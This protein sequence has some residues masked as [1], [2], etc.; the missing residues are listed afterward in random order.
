M[1]TDSPIQEAVRAQWDRDSAAEQASR[2]ARPAFLL[3]LAHALVATAALAVVIAAHLLAQYTLEFLTA[4]SAFAVLAA[5]GF[6]S[7]YVSR[8]RV[9]E[10]QRRYQAR[11]FIRNI[12][13]QDMAM[14][15]D[16]TQLFNR[17]YF[18]DRLQR[19]L[20]QAR[21]FQ[22][23]LAVVVLDVDGLKS[24]NDVHGHRAGDLLLAA[25]GRL[26]VEYTRTCDVPAR[27][28]GD[29]FAVIMPETDKAGAFA[30]AGRLQRSLE[31]SSVVEDNGHRL[32][33]NVSLGVSGY[34]WGG[35]DVDQLV[36]WADTYMYAAKAARRGKPDAS[37]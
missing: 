11:L 25:M 18:Y 32:K 2:P 16:L 33:L 15:D 35:D 28:G 13:L 8:R 17:R 6:L 27:I 9:E 19:E 29:E 12:E 4:V 23:P 7:A 22:R 24:V 26:L 14:R 31:G 20:D 37:L 5:L 30:V 36:Q 3:L 21:T 1:T 34:P 10:Y